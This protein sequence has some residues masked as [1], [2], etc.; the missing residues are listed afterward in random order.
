MKLS[1]SHQEK[2]SRGELILRT[3]FGAFYISLPH[4]FMLGIV[5]I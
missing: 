3:L 5:G 2:Y 4:Q 1:V